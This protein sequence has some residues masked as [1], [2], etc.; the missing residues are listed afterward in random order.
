MDQVTVYKIH[1]YYQQQVCEIL[2]SLFAG[3]IEP[4]LV[5]RDYDKNIYVLQVNDNDIESELLIATKDSTHIISILAEIKKSNLSVDSNTPL[6]VETYTTT[7]HS[8]YCPQVIPRHVRYP[9][10]QY[11]EIT[12]ICHVLDSITNSENGFHEKLPVGDLKIWRSK[13]LF[14]FRMDDYLK[15][16]SDPCIFTNAIYTHFPP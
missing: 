11:K 8:Y 15:V 14:A 12:T 3:I 16:F 6:I 13:S 5:L 9:S 4:F 2:V 7:M 1:P 10:S